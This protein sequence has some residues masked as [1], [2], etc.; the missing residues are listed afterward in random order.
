M[1]NNT[2]LREAMKYLGWSEFNGF[3]DTETH[4]NEDRTPIN[5]PSK[6]LFKGGIVSLIC[7]FDREARER[8]MQ[9]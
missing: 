2:E 8:G 6:I 9:I 1:E 3:G 7:M 5:K 4:W